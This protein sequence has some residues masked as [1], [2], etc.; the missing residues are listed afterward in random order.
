MWKIGDLNI[1]GRVVLGPMSGV[2]SAAYREF[3]GPFGA[4]V[5]ISEMTSDVGVIHGMA[6]T[7]G[8]VKFHPSYP[9]GL[10]LFGSDPEIMAKAASSALEHNPEISFIDVN[11]GCPVA[12]VIRSGSGSALMRCPSRC[13]DIVRSIRKAVD[14]PITVK[15]RLGWSMEELN[16]MDIIEETVS[17]GA[18]AVTVHARTKN[19]GY[20][21]IP[22]YDLVEDLQDMIPVPLI[23]SGNIYS[24]EDAVRAI[25]ITKATAVM[26]AR[27]GIGN[28]FLLTQIDH[29][30][31]TGEG[32]SNPTVS[33]QVG[34]CI[35]LADAL[36]AERGEQSAVRRMRSFAPKFVAGCYRSR[37]YRNRLAVESVD[38]ASLVD[39]LSEIESKMGSD[40][41]HTEGRLLRWGEDP[42]SEGSVMNGR[43]RD[44]E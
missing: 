20:V 16:F 40:A 26:V 34:W 3:M 23:I 18:E 12:K 25:E 21:G 31:R 36:I 13:G 35:R 28:P 37:E 15:I 42:A 5:A 24:A 32:L 1:D 4:S 17:A 9:T 2:T 39:L 14:V 11:M 43:I 19:D 6:R 10:Q 8:Y 7:M 29:S 30:L 33:E 38:R 22:R 44:R 41:V 27:G